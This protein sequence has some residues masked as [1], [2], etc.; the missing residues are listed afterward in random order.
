MAQNILQHRFD[1]LHQTPPFE[2]ISEESYLPSFKAL[3]EEAKKEIDRIVNDTSIPDFYNTIVSLEK[4]GSQLGIVSHIFFNLNHAETNERIQGIAREVSPLLTEY[5]NDIWLN[6]SLFRKVKQVHD[7]QNRDELSHEQNQL[8]DETYK[9]FV[10]KGALLERTARERYRE[11]TTQLS[12]LTLQFG[13]NLLAETNAFQLHITNADELAG[14]PDGVME[15]ASAL[16]KAQ[17]KDGWIFTLQFPSYMPFMKYAENRALRKQMYMAYSKRGNNENQHDN[18]DLI[19]QIVNLRVEKAQLLGYKSHAHFV[20][21]EHMALHP[22]KVNSFLKEL[23]DASLDVAKQDVKDVE[24][25]A[26]QHGFEGTLQRW[27]YA[28]YS[29]KL[30]AVKYGLDDEATRPYFQLEKVEQGVLGLATRLYGITFK[31][32]KAISVYHNEVKTYEV[33]D[34]DGTFLSVFYVDYF[35]RTTKQGGAWMTSFRDQHHDGSGD[36]RP[37]ISI[38]C[39]FTRP[40][41]KKPSLLTFNEVQTFLHEFGHALHGM[42]SK[43]TY[44]SLAGTNVYRDFVEL[45]SQIMENWATQKE[46]LK[47]VGVHY[48]TDEVIPDELIQKIIDSEN[49]QSGYATVRQLSFG[50]NDMAWHSLEEPFEGDV[51]EFEKQ[52]M[53]PTELFPTVEGTAFSTGFAHIF[54]GG[55]AAGYYGYKWAE[56]LDA[57][58]FEAFKE[59]GIFDKDTAQAFRREILEKGGTAHPMLLYKNFRGHEPSIDPL[60]KR[61]GLKK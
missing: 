10:R 21:E 28:F 30:K 16:A 7:S 23:L 50:M 46:W 22:D 44:E 11:I 48:Q 39:N 17:G 54:D 45:P 49:Y 38:V 53:A 33:F 13:E 19:R 31:E 26:L 8:L 35:P 56:V 24:N 52:A 6:A 2:Q 60:L 43:V 9:G 57:D 42:F 51:I 5:S 61:C 58:A 12:K 4:S 25:Y 14:L 18:K 29:E 37:H 47:D 36:V 20:L 40:T 32:S 27:D 34:T 1:T 41:D 55:Y 59:N 15:A 3:I